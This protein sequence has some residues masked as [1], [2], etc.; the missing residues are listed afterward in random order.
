MSILKLLVD[1]PNYSA[2]KIRKLAKQLA[3]VE[4]VAKHADEPA[5]AKGI[6]EDLMELSLL[7]AAQEHQLNDDLQVTQA[8]V[9]VLD[10]VMEPG[11][12]LMTERICVVSLKEAR[13]ALNELRE[14]ARINSDIT[15]NTEGF[16]AI[17][18]RC[19]GILNGSSFATDRSWIDA[20][21]SPQADL[22]LEKTNE[23]RNS[24]TSSPSD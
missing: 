5:V 9:K 10:R 1:F 17:M 23:N 14:Y 20:R 3:F 2:R 13:R 15:A 16:E 18:A 12:K 7:K 21:T 4:Q 19:H 11:E 6:A 8:P 22:P 24:D